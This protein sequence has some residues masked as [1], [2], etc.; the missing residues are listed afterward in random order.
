MRIDDH[1][2]SDAAGDCWTRIG[3]WGDASCTQLSFHGHCRSCPVF[4]K[5]ALNLLDREPPGEYLDHWARHVSASGRDNAR[6]DGVALVFR[7]GDEWFALPGQN[8]VEVVEQRPI[9]R[10]PHRRGQVLLGMLNIRGE[11]V[12]AASMRM[13]LG[14]PAAAHAE[15]DGVTKKARVVVV[16]TGS[17]RLALPVE[18]VAGVSRFDPR[19]I[20]P[21][22]STVS[23]ASG[24][25]LSG[26]L[27]LERRTLRVLE[28]RA[29]FD[30]L[31][32]S[33]A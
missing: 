27:E 31:N 32:R 25:C 8:V 29:L 22:P 9:R 26:V 11:L 28:P 10:I 17:G 1:Q 33:L 2:P 30:S 7:V 19:L 21:V 14:I 4:T 20:Q 3:V 6:L 15:D 12:L 16:D 24:N 5:A 13:A 18:E 23:R